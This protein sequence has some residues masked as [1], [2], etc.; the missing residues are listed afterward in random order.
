M[1]VEYPNIFAN[2]DS[3]QISPSKDQFD[4][5]LEFKQGP[6]N[7][8]IG[9]LEDIIIPLWEEPMETPSQVEREL[10]VLVEALAIWCLMTSW[11]NS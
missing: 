6:P 4:Q 1:E 10:N 7:N 3:I 9:D 8:K 2:T 5:S 11:M